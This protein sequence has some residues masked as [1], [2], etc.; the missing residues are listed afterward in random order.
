[1]EA[2]Q[3]GNEKYLAMPEVIA[4]FKKFQELVDSG[5]HEA[6]RLIDSD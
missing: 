5:D 2:W 4:F 6:W 3:K 1:M